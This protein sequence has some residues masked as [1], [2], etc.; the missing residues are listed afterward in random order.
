MASPASADPVDQGFFGPGSVSWRVHRETTVLFGGARALLMDAAHPLVI[1]GARETGFYER[2]PWKRL[3]RTL[4]LTYALT[5]GSREEAL[6]AAERINE[7]HRSV[8]GIDP[9]TGLAYDATDPDLL[10]WVHACLVDSA[11][12]FERWTVGRLGP[13]ERERF[14]R[15]QMLT[16]ELLGL[17]RERIPPTTASLRAYIDDVVAGDTLRVTDASRS[18]AALFR[19]PPPEAE[20]R[21]VLRAVAWWAFGSLPGRLRDMY[22][23]RWNPIREASLRAT[24]RSLRLARPAIPRRFRWILPAQVAHRRTAGNPLLQGLG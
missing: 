14:H 6:R 4:G 17:P 2:N 18:V 3:E 9:V 16:A 8:R 21:P 22:G 10:L 5:F 24:L 13:E 12:L 11:L 1:A 19:D 23:I 7:V 20:W 15:E